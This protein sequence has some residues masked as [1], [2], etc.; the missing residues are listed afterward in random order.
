MATI[1]TTAELEQHNTREKGI[2][3]SIH[4]EVYN[5]TEFLDE[6]PGGEEVLLEQAGMDATEGFE[7]VGHSESARSELKQYLIGSMAKSTTAPTVKSATTAT[8]THTNNSNNINKKDIKKGESTLEMIMRIGVP[9]AII[10]GFLAYK[11]MH[12][13]SGHPKV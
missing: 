3:F 2:W 4:G 9:I 10:V 5:V 11:Y 1:I 8:S 7:D 6:H 12:V 13:T